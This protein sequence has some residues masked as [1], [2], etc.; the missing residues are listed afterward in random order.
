MKTAMKT[1]MIWIM[2]MGMLTGCAQNKAETI[3][4]EDE[5]APAETAAVQQPVEVICRCECGGQT[6]EGTQQ[7]T[8]SS[9]GE[10]KVN[11]N[12][13]DEAQLQTLNGIGRT[14][15]QAIIA[16]RQTQGAFQNIE[17]IQNV[18]GIKS[19]VYDKI[20]DDISVG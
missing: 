19:G 20:K 13:A 2:S 9:A 1:I 4:L 11:I 8:P 16:Y 12:T 14:R 17:D 15:A 6:A 10:G 3:L 18:D 7:E 5:Q